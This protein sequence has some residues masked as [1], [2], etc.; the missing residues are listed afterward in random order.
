MPEGAAPGAVSA[1]HLPE[2][3]A[4]LEEA[5]EVVSEPADQRELKL[6]L[7]AFELGAFNG[8]TSGTWGTLPTLGFIDVWTDSSGLLYLRARYMDP[9]SASFL[10]RD[11]FEGLPTRVLSH[12][13]C[14]CPAPRLC[15]SG[16]ES[17]QPI[18][19]L[20]ILHRCEVVQ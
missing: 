8:L 10:S 4:W 3:G 9:G 18:A 11:P 16:S 13:P 19:R 15:T 6:L 5:V 14:A 2:L 1:Y 7:R 17:H 12:R 20:P